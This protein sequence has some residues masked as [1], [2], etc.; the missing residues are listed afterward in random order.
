MNNQRFSS[1]EWPVCGRWAAI[2]RLDLTF[3]FDHFR[4]NSVIQSL[5]ASVF[6]AKITACLC[7]VSVAINKWLDSIWGSNLQITA[8]TKR[9]GE[10]VLIWSNRKFFRKNSAL[11]IVQVWFV[12]SFTLF[13]LLS[14]KKRLDSGAALSWATF[15]LGVRNC[16][17]L[18]HTLK[19]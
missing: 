1:R 9:L 8:V 4:S 13:T 3:G 12:F 6:L 18:I 16:E 2:I 7:R 17:F 15:W 19:A 14:N 5:Y 11:Y 10:L